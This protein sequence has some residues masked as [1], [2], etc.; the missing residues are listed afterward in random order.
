MDA[1]A[2]S[3]PRTLRVRRLGRRAYRPV[4]EAMRSFTERRGADTVDELWLV[5]HEPVYTLGQAG[6]LEHVLAPGSIE[7]IPVDRGGQVTY[8][9]PGQLVAYPLLDLRRLG[10]GVRQLVHRI[11][12]AIIE[13]LGG[14]GIAAD[15]RE[16]APGVY[17]GPAKIASLGLRV[18][19]G[20][21][22]HG[23]AFNIDMDLAPFSGIN[24]CGF[25]GLAVTRVLDFVPGISVA[26]VEP[27]LVAAL[28]NQ[29]GLLPEPAADP[30]PSTEPVPESA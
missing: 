28:A 24:P 18:R 19:R 8:H 3:L 1:V 23:L 30:I 27:R 9:G 22:Y 21:S 25:R 10:L 26:A 20:C 2:P 29:L 11:E 15:R 16:G 13:V 4:W 12:E 5:E 7:V 14:Y 6:R 17:V